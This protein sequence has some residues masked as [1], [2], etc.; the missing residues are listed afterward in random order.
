MRRGLRETGSGLH[1]CIILP[2]P[3]NSPM[4]RKPRLHL[5]GGFYHAMLRGNGGQDI[6]FA[7][8]DRRRFLDLL[9]REARVRRA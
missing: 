4:A 9:K 5:P 1:K 2:G 8:A 7:K 3:L 6:F